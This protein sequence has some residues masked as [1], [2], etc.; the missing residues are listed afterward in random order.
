M[1]LDSKFNAVCSEL[2]KIVLVAA[3]NREKKKQ[4]VASSSI[5][6]RDINKTQ[7]KLIYSAKKGIFL[8]LLSKYNYGLWLKLEFILQF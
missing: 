5:N 8:I 3:K 2:F 7:K 4:A 6:N 1:P